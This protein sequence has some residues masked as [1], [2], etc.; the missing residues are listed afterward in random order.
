MLRLMN[1]KG[2]YKGNDGQNRYENSFVV[3][4]VDKDR[5]FI[6]RVFVLDV[7]ELPVPSSQAQ[8]IVM[9]HLDCQHLSK[10]I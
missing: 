1:S 6:L 3:R 7:T 4:T 9:K 10:V 8:R 5:H 2:S